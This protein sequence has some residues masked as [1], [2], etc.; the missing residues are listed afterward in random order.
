MIRARV[1]CKRT[2]GRNITYTIVRMAPD[3]ILSAMIYKSR[4]LKWE[5]E[6][7]VISSEPNLG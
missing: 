4:K 2:A 3:R 7:K 1:T 5:T 6:V